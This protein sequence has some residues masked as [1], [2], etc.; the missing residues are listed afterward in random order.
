MDNITQ[1]ILNEILERLNRI[2]SKLEVKTYSKEKPNWQ[3]NPNKPA[4]FKQLNAIKNAGGEIWEGMT[5]GEVEEAFKKIKRPNFDKT[6][7][8]VENINTQ[9]PLTKE[10][11]KE[12]DEIGY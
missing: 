10:E 6:N 9:I 5:Q 12:L 4:T 1:T 2:E 7:F 8:Q 3:I 11:I